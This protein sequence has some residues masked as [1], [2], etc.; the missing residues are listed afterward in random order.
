M[1]GFSKFQSR[2]RQL[3]D[4]DILNLDNDNEVDQLGDVSLNAT[5]D[6]HEFK[7]IFEEAEI[8]DRENNDE[9]ENNDNRKLKRNKS[10]SLDSEPPVIHY[11]KKHKG[12]I[13]YTEEEL[14]LGATQNSSDKIVIKKGLLD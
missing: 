12:P 11:G 4:V 13:A 7:G 10:T 8:L 14:S 3:N 1:K 6:K 2:K 9:F 5:L